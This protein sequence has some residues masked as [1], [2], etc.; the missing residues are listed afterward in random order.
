VLCAKEYGTPAGDFQRFAGPHSEDL[1]D[2]RHAPFW[3]P[4]VQLK[5]ETKSRSEELSATTDG[6]RDELVEDG[7]SG[8]LAEPSEVRKIRDIRYDQVKSGAVRP[9]E[10]EKPSVN[11]A[12]IQNR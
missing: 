11:S 2:T 4:I 9:F 12:I 10:A 5:P 3:T 7:M 1:F 8:Y 6:T